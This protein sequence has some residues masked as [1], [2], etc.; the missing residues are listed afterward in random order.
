MKSKGS[1]IDEPEVIRDQF[2]ERHSLVMTS[3]VQQEF[4]AIY[5]TALTKFE[6]DQELRI[7]ANKF[8]TENEPTWGLLLSMLDRTFEHAEASIVSYL[9][10]SPAS[11]EVISRTTVE[12]SLNI[13]YILKGDR[14]SRLYQYFLHY[15]EGEEKEVVR[16]LA[17]TSS[18]DESGAKVHRSSAEKKRKALKFLQEFV[19]RA[20]S[21]LGLKVVENRKW[22]NISERFKIL[23]LELDHRTLY[24]AMCSQTHNDAEDLLNYFV[25]V[26]L[27][28]E[29]LRNKI[30]LETIN[31]SRL[32]IYS[33]IRYYIKASISYAECFGLTKAA[34]RLEYGHRAISKTLEVIALNAE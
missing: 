25:F 7:H 8:V 21:E 6:V 32:L 11:S 30:A 34:K 31:F 20:R 18:I 5:W 13:M 17:L 3:F 28:N 29:D 12:S 26:S 16:W 14:I 24:A 22:P 15:F 9:T 19:D 27:G 4:L 2:L 23:G 1:N 10:G 33:G